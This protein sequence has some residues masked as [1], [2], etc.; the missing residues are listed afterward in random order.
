LLIAQMNVFGEIGDFGLEKRTSLR[1]VAPP[2]P[3]H[4]QPDFRLP[5]GTCA[6]TLLA[7]RARDMSARLVA[8]SI[9]ANG[10]ATADANPAISGKGAAQDVF[11]VNST[12]GAAVSDD[13]FGCALTD[14]AAYGRTSGGD[15]VWA[16][17]IAAARW[18]SRAPMAIC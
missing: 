18:P 15:I 4:D 10:S 3:R 8:M 9:T 1:K 6:G 13:D 5:L 12:H 17:C 2:S 7:A 14:G 16:A 11:I